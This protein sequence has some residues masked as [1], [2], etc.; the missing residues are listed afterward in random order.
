MV[1][2]R[3]KVR[4]DKKPMKDIDARCH[5]FMAQC[6]ARGVRL[7]TQRMAVYRA[8]T[9]DTTHP[10]ADSVYEKVQRTMPSLSISTVYRILESLE[11]ERLI[12]RVSA[13]DG[14]TRFDA[15]LHPHQHLL[16]RVCGRMT[17]FEEAS[18]SRL[19][20]PRLQSAGFLAEELDI[21]VVGTCRNCRRAP[22]AGRSSEKKAQIGS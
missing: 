13:H 6:R 18:L 9:G 4:T 21:R 22:I 11:S 1:I 2:V 19:R 10:T 14:V 7:T 17:D 5:A 20:L 16:C 3:R 12:R 8:L 15:N